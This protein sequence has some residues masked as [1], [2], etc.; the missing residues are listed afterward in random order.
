VT[1][2]ELLNI[3]AFA[4]ATGLSIVALRHYDDI[5][6]LKPTQVDPDTGYRRYSRDQ[7]EPARLICGLR[8]VDLPI[9]QVRA[10]LGEPVEQ[11][12]AA[13]HGHREQLVAQVRELSQRVLAVDEFIEKGLPL[14]PVQQVRPVQL[15]LR[16]ADIARAAA[17]YTAA[18]DAVYVEAISSVQF[19]TYRTDRFFLITLEDAGSPGGSH[20]GLLVDDVDTAHA[21]AL[22][23]GA[24]E[25]QPPT[26]Y[27]WKPRTS[28]VRDPDGNLVDLSQG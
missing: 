19:G 13:L 6:L 25:V 26:E 11:V 28:C 12:H 21:R 1:E 27:A 5:G 8:A 22:D 15:R 24:V 10:V 9:D 14:P 7:V 18:F 4:V 17:F 3:G 2:D 20:F 16:V 23:A